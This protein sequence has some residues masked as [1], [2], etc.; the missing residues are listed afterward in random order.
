MPKI[1]PITLHT[2]L[3]QGSDKW[4]KLRVQDGSLGSSDTATAAGVGK[5]RDALLETKVIAEATG[6]IQPGYSNGWMDRG[7]KLEPRAAEWLE[8][9]AAAHRLGLKTTATMMFGHLETPAERTEHLLRVRDL[10]DATS[11][12]TAFIPWSFQPANT[13]LGGEAAGSWDYLKTLAISR[14]VSVFSGM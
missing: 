2:D 11:G 3:E 4:H 1:G 13:N 12:F 10:Q 5:T 7:T 9:M 14:L 8:V 6:I